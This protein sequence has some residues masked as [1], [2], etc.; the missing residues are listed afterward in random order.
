[1]PDPG[2]LS[3][4]HTCYI[5]SSLDR[6]IALFEQV[7]GLTATAKAVRAEPMTQNTT[8][9]K[10]AKGAKGADVII[11][12]LSGPNHSI[13]L[14]EYLDPSGRS[15]VM[16]RPCAIRPAHTALNI[17]DIDSVV[18]SAAEFDVSP[19]GEITTVG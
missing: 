2:I 3:A 9:A 18:E 5:V 4:N 11:V 7:L 13:E 17:A 16:P 1:L 14:A 15:S 10:G 12:Y 8:G 19:I 6:S